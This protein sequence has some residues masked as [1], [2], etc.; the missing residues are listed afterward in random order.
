M[1]SLAPVVALV[2]L[3]ALAACASPPG[4]GRRDADGSPVLERLT[5]ARWAEIGPQAPVRM[6]VATLVELSR[7]GVTAEDIIQRYYQ[8]GTRLLLSGDELAALRRDGVDQRVLD[9]IASAR[10]DAAQIDAIT[11]QADQDAR[12]RLAYDRALAAGW[13]GTCW[14][15]WRPAVLPYAGFGWGPGRSG[16]FGGVALGF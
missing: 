9:Y 16:W 11:A 7:R 10:E 3:L 5:P 8:T 12:T 15:C 4:V 13:W 14:G 1:R 6:S 2:G